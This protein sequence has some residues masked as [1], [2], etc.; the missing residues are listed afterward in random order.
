MNSVDCPTALPDKL[1]PGFRL[2]EAPVDS[3][4]PTPMILKLV[5]NT[6]PS[7]LKEVLWCPQDCF[8]FVKL[9]HLLG[10]LAYSVPVL[11]ELKPDGNVYLIVD[12]AVASHLL[13]AVKCWEGPPLPPLVTAHVTDTASGWHTKE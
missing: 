13:V 12:P 8:S 3:P 11:L 6:Y 10:E 2:P 7:P 1:H 9:I 4:P 5:P